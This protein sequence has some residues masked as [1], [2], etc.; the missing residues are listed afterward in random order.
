VPSL[1]VCWLHA[2][3]CERN[4]YGAF[5]LPTRFSHDPNICRKNVTDGVGYRRYSCHSEHRCLA[6]REAPV[7]YGRAQGRL[8]TLSRFFRHLFPRPWRIH[9][10]QIVHLGL[11]LGVMSVLCA[12]CYR[13]LPAPE[14]SWRAVG[15]GAGLPALLCAL[16]QVFIGLYLGKSSIGSA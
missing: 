7:W 1:S 13:F 3:D 5:L 12:L 4:A 8:S 9:V 10:W 15:S 2:D 16:S 6:R 11:S 14:V